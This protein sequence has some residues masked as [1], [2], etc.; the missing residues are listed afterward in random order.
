MTRLSIIIP[1]LNEARSLPALLDALK[2]QTRKPDEIIVADAGSKDGTQDLARA[3]GATVVR[4]GRPGPGRNAGARAATGDLLFFLDADVLPRPNFI[5]RALA[6]FRREGYA[7]ATCLITPLD[8]DAS[9]S[10]HL[11]AEAGNLYLQVVEPFSPHAPGFCILVKREVHEAIGGFDEKVKLAEDHDYVQRAARHGE[12]GVLTGVQIPVSMRRLE[13]EGLTKLAFK[14]LWCEMHALA[15][16]PIYSTP[17]EYEMG[18]HGQAPAS[19]RRMI[20]IAQLREQ[21]GRFENPLNRLSAANLRKLDK[22]MSREWM[23]TARRRFQ[24]PLDPPDLDHFQR[25]LL[26]RLALIRKTGRPLRATLSKLQT[27]PIKESVR[28]LD[29]N[30]LRSRLSS[31]PPEE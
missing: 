21:L 29:L 30:W 12:F 8:E 10:D 7:V 2:A 25:Y 16:K 20:D 23:G 14:Y 5:S 15:G 24:L 13:K 28:L 9:A 17:F 27:R 31:N 22:L 3:K 4:G 26:R 1:S 6:E 11:I 18:T 19:A